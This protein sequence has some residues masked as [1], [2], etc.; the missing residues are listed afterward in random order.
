MDIIC[1]FDLRCVNINVF[2]TYLLS[3]KRAKNSFFSF[4][5]YDGKQSSF[6]HL[7]SP[8]GNKL[9]AKETLA[10]SKMMKGLKK[11]IA[12]EISEKSLQIIDGNDHISFK[13]Y[14]KNTLSLN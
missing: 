13:F 6:V 4:S 10:I 3:L 7:I 1:P 12:N 2:L 8:S 14:K 11:S 9:D 5:S